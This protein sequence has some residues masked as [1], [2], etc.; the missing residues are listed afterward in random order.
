MYVFD[1]Y[2]S[3]RSLC[4]G[5]TFCQ[6]LNCT[7]AMSVLYVSGNFYTA[8]DGIFVTP[9]DGLYALTWSVVSIQREYFTA[10]LT[11]NG[12]LIGVII[13]DSYTT[14]SHDHTTGFVLTQVTK[15]DHVYVRKHASGGCDTRT[16]EHD[17]TTF[18][19]F[20]LYADS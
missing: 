11:V 5:I 20:R 9:L 6:R 14:D 8:A 3:P 7:Q 15:G 10:E 18:A 12:N 1:R 4:I 19:G 17:R 16:F 13:S 2:Y